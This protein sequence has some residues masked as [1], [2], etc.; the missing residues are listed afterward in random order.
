[1]TFVKGQTSW[2]KG[3][4]NFRKGYRHSDNIENIQPLC[5]SCNAKKYTKTIYYGKT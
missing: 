3:I 2:N 4:K 5:R 1:M